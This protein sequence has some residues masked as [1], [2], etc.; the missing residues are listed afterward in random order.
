MAVFEEET[1]G[2]V[3]SIYRVDTVEEAVGKANA[4]PFGL[5]FSVWSRDTGRAHQI[6]TRLQAGSVNVN[7]G[8]AASW[9]SLDAP[10]GG[11]KDSG[12]GRRHGEHG[13]LKYTEPQTVAIQHLVPLSQPPYLSQDGFV[14]LVSFALRLMR[15]LPMIK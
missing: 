15:Y 9:A 7:E 8:Y 12:V 4:S 5:N 3:V 13:L 14:S 11:F 1:F 6:A 2:P 10:M